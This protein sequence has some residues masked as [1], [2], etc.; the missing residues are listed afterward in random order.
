MNNCLGYRNHKYF[1]TFIFMYSFYLLILL[2]ETF[3]HFIEIF[4]VTGWSCLYTDSMCTVNILLITLHVPVFALQWHQQCGTLCK[5]PKRPP[6]YINT[7]DYY[8]AMTN[9]FEED[10]MT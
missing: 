10:R 1:I 9:S 7:Q 5:K 8:A 6:R 4:K 3:R 2:F